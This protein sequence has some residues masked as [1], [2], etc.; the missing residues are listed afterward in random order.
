METKKLK[1]KLHEVETR[2]CT[3]SEYSSDHTDK[4]KKKRMQLQRKKKGVSRKPK[5][6]K[7]K[8]K[9]VC[10]DNTNKSGSIARKRTR[11]TDLYDDV[12]AKFSVMERAEKVL[13]RL[14]N[15]LPHFVKCMLPSNVAHGFWL[16]LPK[17]FCSVHLPNHD[18]S[19]VLVDEWGNEYKT[20]Y[21]LERHGLSAGWRGFS[22]S[23]RLL[24]G[25]ILIFHLTGPC[26]LKVHIVRVNDSDVVGAALCLMDM[27]A[28][29]RGTNAESMKRDNKKRKKTKYVEP[30]LLDISTPL[31]NK[32]KNAP[33]SIPA[34]VADR[35]ASSE[36]TNQPQSKDLCYPKTSFLHDHS[37]EGVICR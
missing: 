29:R 37:R 13:A 36:I 2:N 28:S 15:E 33:S 9:K 18:T 8:D 20:S 5:S 6:L 32:G 10:A 17:K 19:I 23:H 30:F 22:I 1:G 31:E 3:A 21:L 14:E 27:D 4:K 7:S 34:P 12:E 26:K 35:S 11:Y 24:K 16:H 25:D